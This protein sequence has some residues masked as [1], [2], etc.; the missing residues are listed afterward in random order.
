MSLPGLTGQSSKHLTVEIHQ[1]RGLLDSRL[2]GNDKSRVKRHGHVVD[3]ARLAEM[4]GRQH[5]RSLHRPVQGRQGLGI[6]HRHIV[7]TKA[8]RFE[9]EA[10]GFR[11]I[12]GA[13]PPRRG[14]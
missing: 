8:Y 6:A 11:G 9:L 5:A 12:V 14:A 13:A 1:G 7:D 3:K 4:H 2:R 10:C